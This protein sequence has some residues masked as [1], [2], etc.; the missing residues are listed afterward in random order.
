MPFKYK[1][2]RNEIS[3]KYSVSVNILASNLR[4]ASKV[5]NL[6]NAATK[7]KQPQEKKHKHCN[8]VGTLEKLTLFNLSSAILYSIIEFLVFNNLRFAGKLYK[9][10]AI[11]PTEN[12]SLA[13]DAL[14]PGLFITSGATKINHSNAHGV[15]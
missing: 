7:N 12:K 5:N 2:A 9:L 4:S 1:S 6:C 8:K 14:Y 10:K 3:P 11:A 13:K 15:T